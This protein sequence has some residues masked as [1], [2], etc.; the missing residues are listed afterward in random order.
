MRRALALVPLTVL[1]LASPAV[2]QTSPTPSPTLSTPPQDRACPTPLVTYPGG[3]IATGQEAR[4]SVGFDT[5]QPAGTY[6]VSLN[7]ASPTP[8]A[9]VRTE[10]TSATGTVFTVRLGETHEFTA[11]M[12]DGGE[13][14]FGGGSVRFTVPVRPSLTI[15]AVRN[16]PRDYS[17]TGRV[18]PG[19]GQAVNLYRVDGAGSRVLTS[20]T[21]VKPDGTY[22]IDRRFSGSGRF[23]FEVR[24]GESATNLAGSSPVRSTLIF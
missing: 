22:R 19:R 21:V 9:V 24:V 20:R 13:C 18:L 5:P 2:A 4:I 14:V 3:G 7:R 1:A 16:A 17:F 12:L 11:T 8:F 15:S 10:Q 23:G 6:T